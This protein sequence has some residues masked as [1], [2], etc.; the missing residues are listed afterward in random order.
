MVDQIKGMRISDATA[1]LIA[2]QRFT[3]DIYENI[4]KALADMYGDYVSEEIME[5][6][7]LKLFNEV[8]VV[9]RRAH[10]RV[11]ISQRRHDRYEGSLRF[12]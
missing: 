4:M 2:C 12:T 11:D 10:H 8:E 6:K 7:C 9:I 5:K 3:D 1:R